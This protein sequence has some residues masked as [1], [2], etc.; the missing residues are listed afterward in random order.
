MSN[1]IDLYL[2]TS[3]YDT[4][5]LSTSPDDSPDSV[6]IASYGCNRFKTSRKASAPSRTG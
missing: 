2:A 3:L 5:A 1:P 6:H 4:L